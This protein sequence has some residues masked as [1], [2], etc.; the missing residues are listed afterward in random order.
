MKPDL[1]Q[2]ATQISAGSV[3]QR[4]RGALTANHQQIF[5][6]LLK[7]T[8]RTQEQVPVPIRNVVEVQV[9]AEDLRRTRKI[10]AGSVD[11][12][13]QLSRI[14]DHTTQAN[15]AR[16]DRLVLRLRPRTRNHRPSPC[17]LMLWLRPRRRDHR[18]S[19]RLRTR[20]RFDTTNGRV[21]GSVGETDGGGKGGS[22]GGGA[23]DG[24]VPD[25]DEAVD[26]P[27]FTGGSG[28][29][30]LP[31]G[32][33]PL[34]GSSNRITRTAWLRDTG[35]WASAAITC[36]CSGRGTNKRRGCGR[37]TCNRLLG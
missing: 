6:P 20:L 25:E 4:L 31:E 7:P 32:K 33:N 9:R 27:A 15:S 3:D 21:N 19:P 18:P 35:C 13:S 30:G 10:V 29:K 1:P 17:R 24:L 37:W 16:R 22:G 26:G 12:V 34:A 28:G 23:E 8:K 11:R 36:R 2:A 5:R 14:V